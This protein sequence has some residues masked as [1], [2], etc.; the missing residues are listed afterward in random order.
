VFTLAGII[1]IS[2]T[3]DTTTLLR[4]AA[5]LF[6][7]ALWD[8]SR[9]IQNSQP[10]IINDMTLK[11]GEGVEIEVEENNE[12]YRICTCKKARRNDA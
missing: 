11:A 4:A 7:S 3:D 9:S 6:V 10:I 12:T 8:I 2:I 1:L 5:I